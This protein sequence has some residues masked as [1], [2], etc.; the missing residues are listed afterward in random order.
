M[1]GDVQ[2]MLMSMSFTSTN[3]TRYTNYELGYSLAY[4]TGWL[5]DEN[6]FA[7]LSEEVRIYPPNAEPFVSYL[8]VGL[9]PRTLD[10]LKAQEVPNAQKADIFYAGTGGVQYLYSSGRSEI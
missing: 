10:M 4:P 3:T 8:D 5:V 6:G 2:L 7:A 9:D 1:D